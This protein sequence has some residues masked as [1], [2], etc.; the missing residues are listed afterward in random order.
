MNEGSL[1][2]NPLL[3]NML[4]TAEARWFID[5]RIP[6]TLPLPRRLEHRPKRELQE[7]NYIMLPEA[8]T[9]SVKLRDRNLE[10]KYLA[11]DF[12]II[13]FSSKIAGRAAIWKKISISLPSDSVIR[14]TVILKKDRWLYSF[15]VN[16]DGNVYSASLSDLPPLNF[17]LE[18]CKFSIKEQDWWSICVACFGARDRLIQ[19]L[20]RACG[21][22]GEL[23]SLELI[24]AQS[25]DFPQWLSLR[26]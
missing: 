5:G 8:T 2:K 9:V 17:N 19:C 18:F 21:I 14:N 24:V 1:S 23:S 16:S 15:G 26:L 13:K 22:L 7:D 6:I 12:G 25:V 20:T 3:D 10:L 4:M 11:Q